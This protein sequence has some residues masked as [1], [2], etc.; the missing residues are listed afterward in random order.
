MKV[1]LHGCTSFSRI[2]CVVHRKTLKHDANS[3][4]L[5]SAPSSSVC[6]A[7]VA[8][9]RTDKH[10]V[11]VRSDQKVDI[12][13][14]TAVTVFWYL[15][16]FVFSLQSSHMTDQRMRDVPPDIRFNLNLAKE[17]RP[18]SLPL[19][20]PSVSDKFYDD[21][22]SKESIHEM[23]H[24]GD[25]FPPRRCARNQPHRAVAAVLRD[26]YVTTTTATAREKR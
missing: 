12:E 19:T 14:T 3:E 13:Q 26:Q 16:R 4:V 11:D 18:I 23:M 1:D 2:N 7:G 8:L 5:I 10:R 25:I 6:S 21:L 22:V 20:Q 15:L 17:K 9:Y 24:P